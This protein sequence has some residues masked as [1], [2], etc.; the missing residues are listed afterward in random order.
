MIHVLWISNI[1]TLIWKQITPGF[2]RSY[3]QC[4]TYFY[5]HGRIWIRFFFADSDLCN[6]TRIRSLGFIN[7]S[8]D[9]PFTL[10][11]PYIRS[12]HKEYYGLKKVIIG[13]WT[14]TKL[15]TMIYAP[16]LYFVIE[17][18]FLA[19][20]K[21]YRR[22][23]PHINMKDTHLLFWIFWLNYLSSIYIFYLLN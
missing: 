15:Q 9:W 20:K 19:L 5:L 17:L 21:L 23:F 10:D 22:V 3:F 4:R 14:F 18:F 11:Q 16:T 1:L 8:I 6:S 12:M 2:V 7:L 13:I